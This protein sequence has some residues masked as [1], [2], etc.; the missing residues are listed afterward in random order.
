M[1]ISCT[2]ETR[3]EKKR[4]KQVPGKEPGRKLKTNV[5]LCEIFNETEIDARQAKKKS[6]VKVIM[7][8]T[9]PTRHN[10]VILLTAEASKSLY[11][12]P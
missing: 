5:H 3:K 10:R 7:L 12:Y 11:M 8:R 6:G 1:C 4:K 2:L 9:E